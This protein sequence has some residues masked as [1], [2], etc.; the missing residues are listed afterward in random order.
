[1]G[2]DAKY[3]V[4]DTGL[5]EDII[6]FSMI[7]DHE[8]MAHRL[9]LKPVSAGFVEFRKSGPECYGKSMSLELVSREVDTKIA[10]RALNFK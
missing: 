8:E 1:M 4:F 5:L 7:R 2:N 6:I 9:R 3:I 10:R